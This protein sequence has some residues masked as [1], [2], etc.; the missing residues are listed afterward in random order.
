VGLYSEDNND[1]RIDLYSQGSKSIPWQNPQ[2]KWSHLNPQWRFTD[3]S[4]NAINS[5]T[6]TN[7]TMTAINGVTGYSASAEFYY[8]DDM[9]SDL[10]GTILIWAVADFSQYPAYL[11][12]NTNAQQVSSYANSKVIAA[13]PYLIHQLTPTG[14]SITRDGINPLL[15]F[16]WKDTQI[17]YVVSVIGT[18]EADAS[19]AVM[20][21]VPYSNM[22]GIS[23]GSIIRSISSIPPSN[24]TWTPDN[25]SAYLSSVDYQNFNV[26]GYLLGEV[27]SN[28]TANDCTIVAKVS[29]YYQQLPIQ[30]PYLWISNPENNSLNRVYAPCV[31]PDMISE[32]ISNLTN[33]KETVY[34]TSYLQISALTDSMGV[35]GFHG[36]YGIALDGIRQVWC[37]DIESDKVYKFNTEGVLLSTIS[38]EQGGTPAGITVDALNDIWVT[39]FDAVSVVHINGVDGS[40]MTVIDAGNP[41]AALSSVDPLFKPILAEPDLNNDIWVTYSNS[42]CSN[43]TKYDS[44]GTLL[45]TIDLPLCSNPMDIYV[46][47]D[48][49]VWVSLNQ[50]SGPPYGESSVRKYSGTTYSLVSTI[51]AYNPVYLTMDNED[52]LYFTH[53]G[54][55]LVKVVSELSSETW[56][57]GADILS[58]DYPSTETPLF[59]DHAL[60]GICCDMYDNI[61]IINSIDNCVYKIVNG[62]AKLATKITPDNNLEWYNDIGSVYSGYAENNKS[63]R[64]FGDWSGNRWFNKYNNSS[65]IQ[66]VYLTGGSNLFNILDFTGLNFRRFNES[67]DASEVVKSFARSPHIADN[68]TL[69]DGYMKAVWGDASSSDGTGFG[70]D[71]YERIAN[72]VGNHSDVNTCNVDQLYNLAQFTDVPIDSYGIN[73]P[74]DIKRVMD[75]ASV[76]QQQ[77]WGSRC[78]CSRNIS[79]TFTTYISANVEVPTDYLCEICG[80]SHPGNKGSLFNPLT[81]TVTA[82]IPFIVEDRSNSNNRYQLITPPMSC[83]IISTGDTNSDTCIASGSEFSVLTTY[84]LSSYYNVILPSIFNLGTS[85]N[86]ADFE[87]IITYFCFYSY[88]PSYCTKQ[89]AGIINW[90][91]EY[92][93]LNETLSSIDDWYGNGETLEKIINY[94]LHKG[95]GLIGD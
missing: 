63:A 80:H 65:S 81:Y 28:N 85:A 10:C 18:T 92:T 90:D 60:G 56:T 8:I 13:V 9:P 1:H 42:L 83:S 55:V 82:F 29:T 24:L 35:T 49:D 73:F 32:E 64:A 6:L 25:S 36:I 5:I 78:K 72:F 33:L 75:V 17:P 22:Y 71:A 53:K 62:D 40:I 47:K 59:K 57:V 67:W 68:P 74:T 15:D 54:N 27:R 2:N 79:N 95:L 91:D 76:N 7:A 30:I 69:W 43:L 70:R 84:P 50:N 66:N 4:G 12:E 14:L 44:S 61:Y 37:A 3:L 19:S 87:Q 77:L 46:T 23:G 45:T 31:N 20:K 52:N 89:I 51:V 38:F 41:F 21:N 11:D 86:I 39:F 88:V 58:E 34:D 94:V 93:T 16:Y 48:N 26:G